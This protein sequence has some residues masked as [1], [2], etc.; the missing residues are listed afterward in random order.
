MALADD[1]QTALNDIESCPEAS[2][3]QLYKQLKNAW[4]LA[5]ARGLAVVTYNLPTGVSRTI[6]LDAA[7]RALET[8][9]RMI[10]S[11]EGGIVFQTAEMP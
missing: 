10:G 5:H 3:R 2:I 11:D 9:Q 8:M 1:V 7:L 4:A 6:G